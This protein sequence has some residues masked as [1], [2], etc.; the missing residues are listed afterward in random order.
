MPRSVIDASVVAMEGGSRWRYGVASGPLAWRRAGCDRPRESSARPFDSRT[1]QRLRD[2]RYRSRRGWGRYV[3][4]LIEAGLRGGKHVRPFRYRHL[5]NLATI[6][7]SSAVAH[8]GV[9]RLRG[10]LAW[11]LWGAAHVF[12]FIGFRNKVTVVLNWLWLYITFQR[13]MRSITGP[14]R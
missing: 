14:T 10:Y 11:L 13:G 1:S 2:R 5:G 6:G 3:T 8:F 9:V 7:C 4:R 12:V